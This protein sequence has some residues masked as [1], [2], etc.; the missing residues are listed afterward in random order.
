MFHTKMKKRVKL[1]IVQDS[2]GVLS[3][4]QKTPKE[5]VIEFIAKWNKLQGNF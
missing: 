2:F 1:N 4:L 3:G 5:R